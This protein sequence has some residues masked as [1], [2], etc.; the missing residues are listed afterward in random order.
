M[1]A[2]KSTKP[3]GPGRATSAGSHWWF[4]RMSKEVLLRKMTFWKMH[5]TWDPGR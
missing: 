1:E 3:A 4:G 5:S 2:G